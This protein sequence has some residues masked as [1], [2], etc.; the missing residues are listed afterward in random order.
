[1]SMAIMPGLLFIYRFRGLG[2]V[3]VNCGYKIIN[4]NIAPK[5]GKR[6]M[7]FKKWH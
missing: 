7:S 1:M 4:K 3:V 2:L 6:E 5:G